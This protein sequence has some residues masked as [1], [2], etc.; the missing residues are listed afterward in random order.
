VADMGYT[1]TG[2]I[3][4][5][6]NVTLTSAGVT[7]TSYFMIASDATLTF[8][9]NIT[10]IANNFQGQSGTLAANGKTFSI[11][12]TSSAQALSIY[13]QQT[14]YNLT[15]DYSALSGYDSSPI[16]VELSHNITVSNN[17]VVKGYSAIQRIM[18]RSNT[19]GTQRTI[20]AANVSM[21]KVDLQDIK[22]AGAGS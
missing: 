12:P 13:G 3:S 8:G 16:F 6:G 1:H 22:G 19:R 11:K 4:F 15:I 10:N 17:L 20:T 7:I 5:N 14:F 21:E 18:L 2:G 9:D